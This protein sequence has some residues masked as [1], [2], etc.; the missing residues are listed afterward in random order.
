M[1]LQELGAI[2]DSTEL[3]AYAKLKLAPVRGEGA[4]VFDERGQAYLDFYGG[5]AVCLTGHCHPKVVAAIREQAG[6]LIFYSNTV[7]SE[8]RA[9][10]SARLLAHAPRPGSRV[11]YCNSGAE[12]N[13]TAMKLARR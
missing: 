2:E 1:D 9:R 6:A 10:A 7:R 5:H 13:E 3:A 12:A 8:V 4:Y 11:F